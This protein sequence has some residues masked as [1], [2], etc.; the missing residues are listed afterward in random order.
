MTPSSLSLCCFHSFSRS[1]WVL[2]LLSLGGGTFAFGQSSIDSPEPSPAVSLA[3]VEVTPFAAA[4]A[5]TALSAEAAASEDPAVTPPSAAADAVEDAPASEETSPE[6]E[7]SSSSEVVPSTEGEPLSEAAL[8]DV[9]ALLP[10]APPPPPSGFFDEHEISYYAL[11]RSREGLRIGSKFSAIYDSNLDM[12]RRSG[13]N[14]ESEDDF[15]FSFAPFIQYRTAGSDWFFSIGGGLDYSEYLEN[16]HYSG[17]GYRGD[18]SLG[19]AGEKASLRASFKYAF[20][21]GTNRYA[22]SAFV[23]EH[24]LNASVAAAYH[25]SRK[26]SLDA[27]FSYEWNEPDVEGQTSYRTES[28]RTGASVMWKATPLF[29]LGPGFSYSRS[30]GRAHSTR[31]TWGPTLT[32]QYQLG[33]KVALNAMVGYDFVEFEGRRSD[34]DEAYTANLDLDYNASQLWGLKLSAY[35]RTTPDGYN[36]GAFRES[37]GVRLGY[38]RKIRRATFNAGVGYEATTIERAESTSWSGDHDYINADASLSVPFL[39]YC[40]GTLFFQWRDESGRYNDD[41]FRTGLS[42]TVTF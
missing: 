11:E 23:E 29:R 31:E 37:T 36:A 39:K 14:L 1:P 25:L 16:S 3:A 26:T 33:A 7:A 22:G 20:D 19:Y 24:R 15:I 42:I 6:P 18:F 32:A 13:S 30:T 8:A 40:E 12:G 35:H 21:R 10:Y 41:A 34:S 4:A 28:L 5:E 17:L 27:Y 38:R 9:I 2:A